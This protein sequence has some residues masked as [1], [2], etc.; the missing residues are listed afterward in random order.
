MDKDNPSPKESKFLDPWLNLKRLVRIAVILAI[1]LSGIWFLLR[2]TVGQKAANQEV[3]TILRQPIDLKN[4]IENLPVSSMKAFPIS[5]PYTGTITIA[6]TVMKGNDIN[7]YLIQPD[8]WDNLKNKT[9]FNYFQ[10]FDALK[11][12][13]YQR[14][15][16]LPQ[17]MYYFVVID[18]TL[19]ILSAQSSD[20]RIHARLEP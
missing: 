11:T 12:K 5:L 18:Q 15:G 19:G 1:P 6:A 16:R 8:Q 17:G 3:A 9:Q 14:S 13:N 20:I 10:G 4:S 2:F 7:I